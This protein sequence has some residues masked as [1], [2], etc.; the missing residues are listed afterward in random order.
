M[1]ILEWLGIRKASP[2][3]PVPAQPSQPTQPKAS[4]PNFQK[5]ADWRFPREDI[6]VMS[7]SEKLN[8]VLQGVY[9]IYD[10]L[11]PMADDGS[12]ISRL[13]LLLE[14]L[15]PAERDTVRSKIEELD[16][17]N[18]IVKFL[19][20]PKS[21]EEISGQ[22]RKS[23]GYAAARLRHLR[24]TGKVARLRDPHT[25]KYKYTKILEGGKIPTVSG[26]QQTLDAAE[27]EKKQEETAQVEQKVDE[28]PS[29]ESPV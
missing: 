6:R 2:P 23:Y 25:N 22:I 9:S 7:D 19:E 1:G 14:N 28:T 24:A 10:E 21:I 11:R 18:A 20:F 4:L 17:D 13:Q 27:E 16:I 8:Y 5:P 3:S 15:T 12:R 26:N 29:P